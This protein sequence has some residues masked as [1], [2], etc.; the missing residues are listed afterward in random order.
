VF[1]LDKDLHGR[2]QSGNYPETGLWE[3]PESLFKTRTKS[4]RHSQIHGF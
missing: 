2:R 4:T 1:S 3:A